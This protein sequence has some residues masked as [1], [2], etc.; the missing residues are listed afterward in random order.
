MQHRNPRGQGLGQLLANLPIRL[1]V[2]G[3]RLPLQI[4]YKKHHV[5]AADSA[6]GAGNA[7]GLHRLVAVAQTGGIDHMQ[8]HALDLYGLPNRVAGGSGN[9]RDDGQLG[10]CQGIE[11]RGFARIGLAGNHH[12]QTV[13][14]Q[15]ALPRLALQQRK[16][17][18]QARQLAVGVGLF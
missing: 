4:V 1:L 5:C 7:Q 15:R 12:I 6:P 14:Q 18:T 9:R 11:Q 2:S 10:A 17:R 8:W 16:L 13:A 3:Q